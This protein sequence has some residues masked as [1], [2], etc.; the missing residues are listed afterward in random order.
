[1]IHY[2]FLNLDIDCKKYAEINSYK[3][4]ITCSFD[5]RDIGNEI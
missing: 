1:M 3:S 5:I 4:E 2:L